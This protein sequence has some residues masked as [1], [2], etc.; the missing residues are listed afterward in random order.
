M[1]DLLCLLDFLPSVEYA[2]QQIIIFSNVD[3][4]FVT[5]F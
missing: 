1:N 2:Q 4:K 5:L 3:R